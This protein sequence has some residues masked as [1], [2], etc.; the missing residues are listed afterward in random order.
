MNT[1]LTEADFYPISPRVCIYYLVSR[2][3][4]VWFRKARKMKLRTCK[5]DS[6]AEIIPPCPR[7]SA[8]APPLARYSL[9]VV[10]GN[11]E[12]NDQQTGLHEFMVYYIGK[13]YKSIKMHGISWSSSPHHLSLASV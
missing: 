6:Q 1:A 8:P 3:D 9:P 10:F 2:M 5:G 7:V 12:C 4:N 11:I 13:L